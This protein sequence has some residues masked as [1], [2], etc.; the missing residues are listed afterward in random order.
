MA[1][2]SVE[3]IEEGLIQPMETLDILDQTNK[4]GTSNVVEELHHRLDHCPICWNKIELQE[5]ALIKGCEHPHCVTCILRWVSIK[6]EQNEEF[7]CPMCKLRFE[8]LYVHRALDGSLHDYLH[9]ESVCLLLRASWFNP[10]IVVERDEVDEETEDYYYYEEGAEAD[11]F[12]LSRPSSIR[13][14]NRRFGEQGY[15]RSGRQ[16]ARPVNRI[17]NLLLLPDH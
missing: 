1:E 13:I 10:S 5:T 2:M 4:I 9:E 7:R 12:Y 3:K 6:N 15:V 14:G 8:S 16:E 11:E 17:N